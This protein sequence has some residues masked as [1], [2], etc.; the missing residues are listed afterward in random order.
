MIDAFGSER[1]VSSTRDL[2]LSIFPCYIQPKSWTAGLRQAVQAA[3]Q[4]A[5]Q[6]KA[7]DADRARRPA[8]VFNFGTETN[9]LFVRIGKE[10]Q[11]IAVPAQ[12]TFDPERGY[13][14]LDG[15]HRH[16]QH[17]PWIR[18]PL[19][20]TGC[21]VSAGSGFRWTVPPGR[22]RI[23]LAADPAPGGTVVIR[24]QGRSLPCSPRPNGRWEA[25]VQADSTLEL[26][27]DRGGHLWWL[28]AEGLP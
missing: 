20:R 1:T 15:S 27:L 14:W 26:W 16:D 2:A 4:H 9:R 19:E 6:R 28:A 3:R 7:K 18:V 8:V 5:E 22:Y 10:R 21:A 17:R 24:T 12:A 13:G 25:E 23:L 11:T